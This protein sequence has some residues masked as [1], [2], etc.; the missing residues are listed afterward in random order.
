MGD[1]QTGMDGGEQLNRHL[2]LDNGDREE[3]DLRR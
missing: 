2:S 3:E 1:R